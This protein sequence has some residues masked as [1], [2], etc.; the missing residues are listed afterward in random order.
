MD[1][2]KQ[3]R[4]RLFQWLLVMMFAVLGLRLFQM[5]VLAGAFYRRRADLNHIRRTP[6]LPSRG[7]ILD[8]HGRVLVGNRPIYSAYVIPFE[9]FQNPL[10]AEITGK[11]LGLSVESI[12]EKILQQNTGSFTPVRVLRDIDFATRSRLEEHRLDLRGVFYLIEPVRAYPTEIRLAHALGYVGEIS[13]EEIRFKKNQDLTLGDSV[14]KSGI[15]NQYDDILRGDR[16]YRFAEVDVEGR[17]V[18]RFQGERDI[19]S[20][21]GR[22]I[23]ITVDADLQRVA[24]DG[25]KEGIGAVVA[26][27]PNTGDVL[28]IL[29]KPDFDLQTFSDGLSAEVW[30]SVLVHPG[31]PLLNR[32]VNGQFP[33]GSTFKLIM[34]LAALESK[35]VDLDSTVHCPGYYTLGRRSFNC[36]EDEGHGFVNFSDAIEV[37]C[38]VYFYQL[39]LK[40]GLSP[41]QAMGR[42]LSIGQP[43]H[44][45]LPAEARGILPDIQFLDKKYGKG[46]W[47]RGMILNLAVGQGDLL[48][49]PIQM[50][51][52]AASISRRGKTMKPHLFKASQDPVTDTWVKYEAESELV[53][54]VSPETYETII[55]AMSRVVNTSKGTGRAARIRD[56]EVC[57]KTGTAENP[58]GDPHAWFIGF[59]PRDNPKI[60]IAVVVE[61][62]GSGGAVA[63]PIA[64]RVLTQ[65]FE[66]GDH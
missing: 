25:M 1:D 53:E 64:G 37:S 21:P 66:G 50:A 48:V 7:R 11:H 20:I 36:W 24:E 18:G 62:G 65:F 39:G 22:N 49:T 29:S 35:T 2:I 38:N 45:D 27:D 54:G 42:K 59:A 16:G 19:A 52:L 13:A 4:G 15:E 57:G 14:G 17:I 6:V 10:D 44:V 33:P 5:Q 12:K 47:T 26:L 34:A 3:K 23:Q 51:Q 30:D 61:N 43:T 32:V 56:I 63:A 60:A 8:R 41:W 31:K 55:D 46:Q 40:T 58:H 28:T 9:F